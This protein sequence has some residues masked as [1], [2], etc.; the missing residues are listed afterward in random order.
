VAASWVAATTLVYASGVVSAISG[1]APAG[2]EDDDT[3]LAGVYGR[4]ALVTPDGWELIES[5]SFTNGE[6]TG[7]IAVYSKSE[8]TSDDAGASFEFEQ[9]FAAG[10]MGLVYGV[11]R[12]VGAIAADIATAPELD[13]WSITPASLAAGADDSILA[14]F[15][16]QI[17]SASGSVTPSPPSSFTLA[18]G[19]PLSLYHLALAYRAV[20]TGQSN[21][22]AFDMAPA[23]GS[24]PVDQT[25][26]LNALGAITVLLEPG[27]AG[28][29]GY[30]S[31][32]GPLGAPAVLAE[33]VQQAARIALPS[34]LA[35]PSVLALHDF[36][37]AVQEDQS[38]FYVM[39]LITPGGLVRAP[40]SSWQAT[41]QT[42]QANYVQCVVPAC[43]PYVDHINAATAFRISRRARLQD[44]TFFEY[45][46]AEAPLDNPSLAQG[47]GN[48]TA[49]LS[50]Y[51]PGLAI[52][53]D[54]PESTGRTLQGVRTVFTQVSGLRVRCAVDWLLRPAQLAFVDGSSFVVAYINYYVSEGDQFMD[55]G[56]R[57]EPA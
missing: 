7:Y 24:G 57:A 40:I 23:A 17:I 36:T 5:G 1:N 31:A 27:G 56:E 35:A 52:D 55:V 25:G 45:V 14:V 32:P 10:R 38:L 43:L 2:I 15:A 3:L 16:A 53:E 8:V 20:D 48:Y 33:H 34:I 11:A 6:L 54:P 18:S 22:G 49:T 37:G 39:D 21:S 4:A 42:E 13:D 9:A 19:A 29:P 41:L 28:I 30:S 47:T 51:S 26:S 12:G 44:G 50:G 46:M